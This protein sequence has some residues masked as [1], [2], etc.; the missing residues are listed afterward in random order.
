MKKYVFYSLAT[1]QTFLRLGRNISK[2]NGQKEVSQFR[3][4]LGKVL[5]T[6]IATFIVFILVGIWHGS[7]LKYLAFG[8]WNG[9]V[10]MI[11]L[12][13]EPYFI[14][15]RNKLKI[16]ET[17]FGHRVFQILRTF[18][19]VLV[20][21]VFDVAIDLQDSFSMIKRIFA[22]QS[23][24]VFMSE[25]RSLGPRILDYLVIAFGLLVMFYIGIR[26]E[27]KKLN[28]PAELIENHHAV[29]QWLAIL[30]G[31]IVILVFGK[32]G[33]GYNANSFVYM[34]F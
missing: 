2:G 32:Y 11:S 25:W 8:I 15:L 19:L 20:G 13:F 6:S 3:K 23:L 34:Q 21:Y 29:L 26:L 16:K 30:F 28:S 17:A 4:H 7:N 10:I 31:I 33:P 5:P 22:D 1:S 27:K 9:L 14:S 12:I 24:S 18:I